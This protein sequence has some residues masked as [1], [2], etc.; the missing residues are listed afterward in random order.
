MDYKKVGD[1]W[2]LVMVDHFSKYLMFWIFRTKESQNVVDFFV[3]CCEV[4]KKRPLVILTDNG[5]EFTSRIFEAKMA[6]MGVQIRHSL[7][8][9]PQTQGKYFGDYLRGHFIPGITLTT[10][11]GRADSPS[12]L[13]SLSSCPSRNGHLVSWP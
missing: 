1:F 8:Y 5:G 4:A 7:P 3:D 9:H 10:R 12:H 11:C 6:E 13:R 2:L